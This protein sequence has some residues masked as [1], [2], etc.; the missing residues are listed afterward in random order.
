[1]LPSSSTLVAASGLLKRI[2]FKMSE[3][4]F[5]QQ[6]CAEVSLVNFEVIVT[7]NSLSRSNFSTF[8]FLIDLASFEHYPPFNTYANI[9]QSETLKIFPVLSCLW[10]VPLPLKTYPHCFH[11]NPESLYVKRCHLSHSVSSRYLRTFSSP[12]GCNQDCLLVLKLIGLTTASKN[13]WRLRYYTES[14]NGF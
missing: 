14:G 4:P 12:A 7:F 8:C 9:P 6:K 10:W 1:M 3:W 11:W 5:L 13:R 2:F